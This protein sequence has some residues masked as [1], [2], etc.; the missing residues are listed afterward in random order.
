MLALEGLKVIDFTR[1][2]SG[3]FCSMQLADHGADV[4]KIESPIDRGDQLRRWGPFVPDSDQS[5]YFVTLNKNKRSIAL[6][7]KSSDGIEIVKK[8]IKTG[9]VL[10]ENF[11]PG[12]M[13]KIGLSAGS[14]FVFV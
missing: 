11:R 2:V 14:F 7:L 6:D 5:Y 9:D 1:F 4:I 10:V 13:D 12:L 8:L 3:P